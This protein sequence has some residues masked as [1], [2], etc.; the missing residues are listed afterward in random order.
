MNLP[1]GDGYYETRWFGMWR[2]RRKVG[3]FKLPKSIQEVTGQTDVPI[4]EF[5]L[6][7]KDTIVALEI[8]EEGWISHNP[9][10]DSALDGA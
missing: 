6:Q 5:L 1:D 2:E 8:C 3:Q 10:I 7:F 9:M 4:G